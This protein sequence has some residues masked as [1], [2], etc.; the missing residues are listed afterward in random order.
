MNEIVHGISSPAMQ[1]ESK[2]LAEASSKA[3]ARRRASG[4]VLLYD[5]NGWVVYEHP[6]GR[7]EQL[8]PVG[9]FRAADFPYP[10]FTPP[11]P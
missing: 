2:A 8:A 3:L 5:L 10:G 1:D 7:I 11:K 9:E 6:G 4:A